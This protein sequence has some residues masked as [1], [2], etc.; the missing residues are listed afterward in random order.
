M[1]DV[2]LFQF[3]EKCLYE[4]TWDRHHSLSLAT[5]KGLRNP[6][7]E[8]NCFLNSAVQVFWHLDVFRRSLK[9]Y[10][11]HVCMGNSC[12]FCN[13][14]VIF[15]Q[16]QY[17]DK[18]SL[19]PNA[20]RRALAE[21]FVDQHRFQLGHMDDAAECFE[22]ILRRIHFHVANGYNEDQCNASHCLTHRKFSLTVSD[23]VRCVCGANSEPMIFSEI[24]HYVSVTA[25]VSLASNMIA[26]GHKISPSRF[27]MLL[28]N[29][30]S[31]GDI[32][33]CPKMCGRKVP[34]CRTLYNQPDVVSIGLVWNS[35][36]PSTDLISAVMM[37]IRTSLYL[38]DMFHSSTIKDL[39]E[40]HLVGLVCYYGKHY[41]TFVFHTRDHSWYYFDDATVKEMGTNWE[42]VVEKCCRSHYQPLLLLYANPNGTPIHT[43]E[44]PQKVIM[45][46]GFKSAP[47]CIP[48][49]QSA[50]LR[51]AITPNPDM[52]SSFVETQNRRAITPGPDTC[53]RYIDSDRDSISSANTDH[54]RQ[55][56]FLMAI[57]GKEDRVSMSSQMTS[58]GSHYDSFSSH[59]APVSV[60]SSKP[61]S[62]TS[63]TDDANLLGEY[64]CNNGFLKASFQQGGN[65]NAGVY[66]VQQ[67]S[68]VERI[69]QPPPI[70]MSK[71]FE[72]QKQESFK[73][74]NRVPADL[75]RYQVDNAYQKSDD[76]SSLS[77]RYK[78]G[79]SLPGGSSKDPG[80]SQV[81]SS[82]GYNISN[83]SHQVIKPMAQPINNH[84]YENVE[85]S[86]LHSGLATLPRSKESTLVKRPPSSTPMIQPPQNSRPASTTTTTSSSSSLHSQYRQSPAKLETSFHG[87]YNGQAR[88]SGQQG[89]FGNGPFNSH[90][91]RSASAHS[92]SSTNS[93]TNSESSF[94]QPPTKTL[95]KS[96]LDQ[97]DTYN[98]D[99]YIDRKMVKN[100]MKRLHM[101]SPSPQRKSLGSNQLSSKNILINGNPS[102]TEL[103]EALTLEIP[104]DNLSLESHRDSGYGSSDRNSSSS[105]SSITMDPQYFNSANKVNHIKTLPKDCL[106]EN[107]FKNLPQ[108]KDDVYYVTQK[109]AI[110]DPMSS[111]PL[112]LPR[113]G[114]VDSGLDGPMYPSDL[115]CADASLGSKPPAINNTAIS[116]SSQSIRSTL[117]QQGKKLLPDKPMGG[118]IVRDARTKAI[119]STHPNPSP[120][121]GTDLI[122]FKSGIQNNMNSTQ[123]SQGSSSQ[124]D[125]VQRCCLQVDDL[126][127]QCLLA[128]AKGDLRTAICHCDKAIGCCKQVLALVNIHVQAV[129]YVQTKHHCCMTKRRTL[130]NKYSKQ[131]QQ[132]QQFQPPNLRPASVMTVPSSAA[133]NSALRNCMAGPM[134]LT[135][136]STSA[137]SSYSMRD[138][139]NNNMV[140]ST[141]GCVQQ[142]SACEKTNTSS[143]K[144]GPLGGSSAKTELPP[145]ILNTCDSRKSIDIYGTLPKNQPRHFEISSASREAGIYQEFLSRQKQLNQQTG[146]GLSSGRAYTPNPPS[147]N[148]LGVGY[149]G[150]PQIRPS[151][152]IPVS[153]NRSDSIPD[154][155]A[156]C[157]STKTTVPNMHNRQTPARINKQEIQHLLQQDMIRRQGS[158]S[159]I[160][161]S[162]S[163]SNCSQNLSGS[164][165]LPTVPSQYNLHGY[166]GQHVDR[167]IDATDSRLDN[168]TSLSMASN[169]SSSHL[170]TVNP[171][172][173]NN[174]RPSSAN[175]APQ[176]I[177][178]F[179]QVDKYNLHSAEQPCSDEESLRPSVKVLA[180]KFEDVVGTKKNASVDNLAISSSDTSE[181][182]DTSRPTFRMRSKSESSTTLPK[183]ALSKHQFQQGSRPRKSVTFCDSIALIALT[184]DTY[185]YEVHTTT[186]RSLDNE[187]DSSS[188]SS[189]SSSASDDGLD[190]T[191][192]TESPLCSLCQKRPVAKGQ[193]YC[194]KCSFYMSRFQPNS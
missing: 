40:L 55:P 18:S 157:D 183:P 25:L 128:E 3:P 126:M 50:D 7:G 20:L 65:S 64:V 69:P 169:L 36:C 159:K 149:P 17:S 166:N 114:S 2:E 154:S 59:S 68:A 119:I 24:V 22:N 156:S 75:I 109:R 170:T 94:T 131:Q 123:T 178:G 51:R 47:N 158:I 73:K 74:G 127:E 88:R 93:R 100:V 173:N 46:P 86:P 182:N 134:S 23:Q 76:A 176:Q 42:N 188:S 33:D 151:S 108:S 1:D 63:E 145:Q 144:S 117:L 172:P 52:H 179:N 164:R 41:S 45:A 101:K 60:Q 5:T 115:T 137:S 136:T 161:S 11:G 113:K 192:S 67:A 110:D 90:M 152:T 81:I 32:R 186:H 57:N 6:P 174:A 61:N 84:Y 193:T 34:I 155:V 98:E 146:N 120:A 83:G 15:T 71:A 58:Q 180:S 48:R 91:V 53:H 72:I 106:L 139:S 30:R 102:K 190:S 125:Y 122:T 177:S 185:P 153:H 96:Y 148:G 8:N 31:E 107:Q 130:Y 4:D 10:T 184:D 77:S 56:S 116:S 129:N 35:D 141:N 87:Y 160:V 37:N 14:K 133:E 171:T 138:T 21:A 13:L 43:A 29:A 105:T 175:S 111:K 181:S 99:N 143:S 104:Y 12:I 103:S 135:S 89:V 38:Q 140:S 26:V 82:N 44:A 85:G 168:P 95:S 189:S 62:V 124:E 121:N 150:C 118:H 194:E 112:Y 27:G 142:A 9:R 16:L 66:N 28:R 191:M 39:P 79:P 70:N 165:I 162:S 132:Q 163:S 49:S 187:F 19:H 80:N 92:L 97:D 147:S 167:D 78:A 54:Q